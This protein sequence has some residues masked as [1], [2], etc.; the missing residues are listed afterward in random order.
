M[1]NTEPHRLSAVEMV[2]R[3]EA[4]TLTAEA[5]VQ[6]CIARIRE[7]E[8]VVRA[9][10]HIA[11]DDGA[12]TQWRRNPARQAYRFADQSFQCLGRLSGGRR[13]D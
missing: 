1:P 7:R 11:G 2:S 5:V 6:S 4:G 9:W 13:V 12:D 3:I 8:P 10:A